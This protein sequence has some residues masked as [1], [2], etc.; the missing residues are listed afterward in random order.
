MPPNE[1]RKVEIMGDWLPT[2][3]F[4][5]FCGNRDTKWQSVNQG[6]GVS[7]RAGANGGSRYRCEKCDEEFVLDVYQE[8][9]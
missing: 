7:M 3:L 2:M 8:A 4:C 9:A 6:N 5:P 1:M